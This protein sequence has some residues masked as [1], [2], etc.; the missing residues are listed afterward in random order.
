MA[1]KQAGL[2]LSTANDYEQ[3]A[4]RR[5]DERYVDARI[6][7]EESLGNSI[8]AILPAILLSVALHRND[9]L[10]R[11]GIPV[12]NRKLALKRHPVPGPQPASTNRLAV[13]RTG[14]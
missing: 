10:S 11:G 7:V 14:T 2:A 9:A 3:L 12:R 1:R 6:A 8:L 13:R 5:A 4:A